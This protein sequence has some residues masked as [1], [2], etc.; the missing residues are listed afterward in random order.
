M[1]KY[2][3]KTEGEMHALGHK[4]ASHLK[5]GDTVLLRGEVGAGKTTF[6]KGAAESLGVKS[7]ILSPT[8]SLVRSH[9]T[10]GSSDIKT[11]YHVDLYRAEESDETISEMLKELKTNNNSV[12]FIEWP[13]KNKTFNEEWAIEILT[14]NPREVHIAN[15]SHKINMGEIIIFPTDTAFGIGCRLDDLNSI[16]NL[17]QLR[18]RSHTKAVPVLVSSI[19]MARQYGEI[20]HEAELL[21]KKFWPG[22]LTIVINANKS[23]V[24]ALV[25]GGGDTVGLRMPNSKITLNM[26]SQTGV[27]ILGP[28]ANFSGE[29]TPYK[30]EDLN[31]SLVKIVNKVIPGKTNEATHSTVLDVTSKPWKILREGAVSR[32]EL[33]I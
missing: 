27:P 2:I 31:P 22:G 21:M 32:S 8:F 6:V 16:E 1:K 9:Q 17:F 25:R 11:I 15:K 4:F 12:T 18:K 23:K 19:D 10:S 14:N 5:P 29:K 13:W 7:R 30:E 3:A 26:I 20:T 33:N 24:P 28:S